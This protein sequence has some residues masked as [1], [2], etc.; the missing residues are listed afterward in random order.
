MSRWSG[1]C[2]LR[3]YA[4]RCRYPTNILF[5]AI[6]LSYLVVYVYFLLMDVVA[7]WINRRDLGTVGADLLFQQPVYWFTVILVYTMTFSIR[8]GW[9]D[10][11]AGGCLGRIAC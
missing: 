8:W 1:W 7:D 10:V 9:G 6:I 5:V 4:A 2:P 3:S 11:A